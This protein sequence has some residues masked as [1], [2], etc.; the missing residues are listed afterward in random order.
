MTSFIAEYHGIMIIWYLIGYIIMSAMNAKIIMEDMQYDPAEDWQQY[1]FAASGPLLLIW[2]YGLAFPGR[3]A[4]K[5]LTK[6]QA[7]Y[8]EYCQILANDRERLL[9]Y[10]GHGG[11]REGLNEYRFKHAMYPRP[12]TA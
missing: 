2:K 7:E 6:A 3:S 11:W 1:L 4:D 10:V 5:A 8:G 12:T 9:H